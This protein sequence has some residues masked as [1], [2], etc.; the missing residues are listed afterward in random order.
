MRGRF[1]PRA[2]SCCRHGAALCGGPAP[3]FAAAL[4]AMLRCCPQ[5]RYLLPASGAG[6]ARGRAAPCKPHDRG[7]WSQAFACADLGADARSIWPET[8]CR[9][10]PSALSV[11]AIRKNFL[12]SQLLSGGIF[13][14]AARVL[15]VFLGISPENGDGLTRFSG[16]LHSC[17][18]AG[19]KAVA[20]RIAYVTN[21]VSGRPLQGMP[22][23][24]F[25]LSHPVYPPVRPF[26]QAGL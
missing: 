9:F 21:C 24:C 6:R 22:P 15:T 19:I 11:P 23:L 4:T 10:L 1:C 12:F 17:R 18:V 3:G 16:G 26:Q 13:V 25:G 5:G 2:S 8:A 20:Q 14:S 7:V